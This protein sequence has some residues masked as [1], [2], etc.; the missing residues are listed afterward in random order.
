MLKVM[1]L[2]GLPLILPS[3]TR[4]LLVRGRVLSKSMAAWLSGTRCS[5]LTFMR[6][7]GIIHV[8]VLKSI[9]DHWAL[10]TSLERTQVSSL[11]IKTVAACVS[12][13]FNDLHKAGTCSQS[14]AG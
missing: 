4:S 6:S 10:R 1:S 13:L 7:A 2:V 9:S 12:L 11:N 3:N 5:V 14:K 8:L